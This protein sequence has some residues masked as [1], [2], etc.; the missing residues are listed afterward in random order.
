MLRGD[1]ETNQTVIEAD[2]RER[3]KKALRR[4]LFTPFSRHRKYSVENERKK[5]K[6]PQ[7]LILYDFARCDLT[8]NF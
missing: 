4:K 1:N 8:E 5:E 7:K 6:K 3:A 2:S